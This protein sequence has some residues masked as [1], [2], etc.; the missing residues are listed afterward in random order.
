MTA[1]AGSGRPWPDL[2]LD[3]L[4]PPPRPPD[5]HPRALG[6]PGTC[7]GGCPAAVVR[8][9]GG[10]CTDSCGWRVPRAAAAPGNRGFRGRPSGVARRGCGGALGRAVQ[11]G[12]GCARYPGCD[13]VCGRHAAT[14]ILRANTPYLAC[15]LA[16]GEYRKQ[17]LVGTPV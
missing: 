15:Q 10:G 13:G 16:V 7:G 17:R 2:D 8:A 11:C 3:W 6:V 14:E 5:L 1:A 4:D 9:S 12:F